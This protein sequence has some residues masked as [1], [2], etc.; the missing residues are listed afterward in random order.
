MSLTTLDCTLRDGGYYNNWNFDESLVDKYIARVI[1]S[2]IDIIE[3]GFRNFSSDTYLGPYA[4]SLDNHLKHK[5]NIK[6]IKVGVMS[7]ASIFFS[8]EERIS[9]QVEQLYLPKSESIISLVRVAVHFKDIDRCKEIVG[10]LKELGY[11]VGLNMMQAG[12]RSI[13]EIEKA[14]SLIYFS[15]SSEVIPIP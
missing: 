11:E 12:G 3:I 6:K 1:E 13:E 14:T 4:Y 8:G 2:G 10:T 9:R 15:I 7:D 5:K